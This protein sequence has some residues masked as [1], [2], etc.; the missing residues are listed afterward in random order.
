M[1]Y[2]TAGAS[3]SFFVL[4]QRSSKHSSNLI[5]LCNLLS[6]IASC[7]ANSTGLII[8]SLI[9]FTGVLSSTFDIFFFLI[10][11]LLFFHSSNSSFGGNGESLKWITFD[12]G[13]LWANWMGDSETGSVV[14]FIFFWIKSL[15]WAPPVCIWGFIL[16][17]INSSTNYSKEMGGEGSSMG[18]GGIVWY[19]IVWYGIVWYGMVW[20]QGRSTG[21]EERT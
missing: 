14:F 1:A 12:F 16:F 18:E 5:F 19:S 11:Y 9:F 6:L 10:F 13:G 17:S 20:W 15:R 4:V 21:K 3:S 2:I 8:S 7:L